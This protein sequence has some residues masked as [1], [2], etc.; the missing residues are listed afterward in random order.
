MTLNPSSAAPPPYQ[1]PTQAKLPSR[2]SQRWMLLTPLLALIVLAGLM[3]AIIWYLTAAEESQREQALRNDVDSTQRSIREKLERNE[4]EL[5][6]FSLQFQTTPS[7]QSLQRFAQIFFSKNPE[8]AFVGWIDNTGIVRH[9]VPTQDNPIQNFGA[10]GRPATGESRRSALR[11]ASNTKK[12]TYSVPVTVRSGDVNIDYHV[13]L[14]HEAESR[15]TLVA[16]Y[17]LQSLLLSAVPTELGNRVA[18]SLIDEKGRWISQTRD[19]KTLIGKPFYEVGLDPLTGLVKL[20]GY[21]TQ[22]TNFRYNDVITIL[23]VGLVLLGGVTQI[24]IWRNT[25]T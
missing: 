7:T 9:V 14:I 3:G 2:R 10:A 22:P 1:P 19:S 4:G 18:F 12:P 13:P 21:N 17:S 11:M 6:A 23:I 25:R 15:G 5:T 16:T 20:R 8:I 24:V